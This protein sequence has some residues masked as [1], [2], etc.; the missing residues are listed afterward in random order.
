MFIVA[1]S[2][3]IRLTRR[4]DARGRPLSAHRPAPD[5]PVIRETTHTAYPTPATSGHIT[6]SG[7][8]SGLHHT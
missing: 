3:A 2:G 1:N 8:D 6:D 7:A 4:P 5:L